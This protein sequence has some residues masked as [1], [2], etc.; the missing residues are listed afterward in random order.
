MGERADEGGE[1]EEVD[2]G[3]DYVDSG[4]VHFV[5]SFAFGMSGER[6]ACLVGGRVV[7]F[8]FGCWVEVGRSN[9]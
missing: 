8:L 2:E 1:I 3:H 4:K 7:S 5:D 6:V 9:R